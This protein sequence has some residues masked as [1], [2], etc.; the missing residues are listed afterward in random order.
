MDDWDFKVESRHI[1]C[2][3]PSKQNWPASLFVENQQDELD[4]L[5]DNYEQ[6]ADILLNNI[7]LNSSN[8]SGNDGTS[9]GGD[10]TTN[11]ITSNS[12]LSV[13]DILREKAYHNAELLDE[14]LDNLGDNLGTLIN[15]INSV[16]D[17]FN[18]NLINDFA[19]PNKETT[20]STTKSTTT[21][22][23]PIEEIVKV[24]NLHLENL[25]YIEQSEEQLQ[26]KLATISRQKK[27]KY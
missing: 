10:G 11:T 2:R 26:E 25:N 1:G 7:E 15:E 9:S 22:E 27:L 24:L 19:D 17:V 5:L 6:Q 21:K 23:N 20:K 12:T 3:N 13:T 16:S 4:K 8:T 18:K 14:R